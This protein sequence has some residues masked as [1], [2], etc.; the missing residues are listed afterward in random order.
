[1]KNCMLIITIVSLFTAN[2]SGQFLPQ[3]NHSSVLELGL[4]TSTYSD[5]NTQQIIIFFDTP[6]INGNLDQLE[7]SGKVNFEVIGES[8]HNT[9]LIGFVPMLKYNFQFD[10][11]IIFLRGGIGANYINTNQVGSRNLG[12]NFIFSDMVG[13]GINIF[14]TSGYGIEISY[15]FRHISNAGFYKDNEGYNSQYILVTLDI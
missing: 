15:L 6:Y 10:D 13:V 5:V 8:H 1:M 3:K 12:G 14:Q 2:I 9:F 4:G 7:Y 11:I